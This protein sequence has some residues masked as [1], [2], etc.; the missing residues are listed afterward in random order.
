MNYLHLAYFDPQ[1]V[2]LSGKKDLFL[3]LFLT[4]FYSRT[5]NPAIYGNSNFAIVL[6][7]KTSKTAQK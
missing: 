3:T 4:K 6:P 5:A 1:K 2:Y 7:M